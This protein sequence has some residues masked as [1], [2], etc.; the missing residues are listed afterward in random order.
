MI[1]PDLTLIMSE[2]IFYWAYLERRGE[3]SFQLIE[4]DPIT[5]NMQYSGYVGLWM[6]FQRDSTGKVVSLRAP[7]QWYGLV[8]EKQTV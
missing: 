6:H 3:D 4:R 1:Y 7:G 2:G 5:C 8:W